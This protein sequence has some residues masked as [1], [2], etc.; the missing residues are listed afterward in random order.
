MDEID[1][2][3]VGDTGNSYYNMNVKNKNKVAYK[4]YTL[5]D[6]KTSNNALTK[7]VPKS[8]GSNVGSDDWL[9]KKSSQIKA[10]EFANQIKENNANSM[11]NSNAL[12]LLP[13]NNQMQIRTQHSGN[14]SNMTSVLR[15]N[16]D[17][18]NNQVVS[19]KKRFNQQHDNNA[20]NIGK[21]KK[22]DN[23]ADDLRMLNELENMYKVD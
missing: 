2:L 8:L 18:V 15:D 12:A 20:K 14:N 23:I 6:Y 17:N 5:D 13:A 7:H 4:P 9:N 11:N 1:K 21:P 3:S 19:Y 16:R 10:K 22:A